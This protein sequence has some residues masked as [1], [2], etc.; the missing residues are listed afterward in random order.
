MKDTG[1]RTIHERL[2]AARARLDLLELERSR[3]GDPLL[4]R[5]VEQRIVWREL[6]D[7]ELQDVD[8]QIERIC[9]AAQ[10]ICSATPDKSKIGHAK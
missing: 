1:T 5:A 2:A 4:G 3:S 10:D 8:E 6:L 9:T 7:L